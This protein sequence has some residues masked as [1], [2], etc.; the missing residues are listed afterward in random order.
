MYKLKSDLTARIARCARP[1]VACIV[2]GRRVVASC[3][4]LSRDQR[5]R[6]NEL[7]ATRT[8]FEPSSRRHWSRIR[9]EENA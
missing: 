7:C 6:W 2:G 8:R 1:V 3:I 5:A 9:V 4:V